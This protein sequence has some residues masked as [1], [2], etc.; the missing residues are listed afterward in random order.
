MS[1]PLSPIEVC[2]MSERSQKKRLDFKDKMISR[3]SDQIESLKLE[4]EKLRLEIREKN[5]LIDSV[6]PMREEL[7]Q[8]IE[9]IKGYKNEYKE[10]VGELR[11]MMSIINNTVF[12]GRWK[13]I[14]FLMK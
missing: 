2:E 4:N 14:R 6:V 5:E 1:T 10:L 11:K 12:K 13:L 7:A 9:E 3:Q 8:H